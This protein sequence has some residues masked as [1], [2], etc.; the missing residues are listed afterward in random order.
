MNTRYVHASITRK[1]EQ[2]QSIS[3]KETIVDCSVLPAILSQI[4]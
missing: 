3:V 4:V 2:P 1:G